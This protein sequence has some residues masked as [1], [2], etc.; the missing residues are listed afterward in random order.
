[1]IVLDG[2]YGHVPDEW[3]QQVCR[4]V[5]MPPDI[6]FR[7][8]MASHASV[9]CRIPRGDQGPQ[10]QNRRLAHTAGEWRQWRDFALRPI[11]FPRPGLQEVL[12]LLLAHIDPHPGRRLLLEPTREFFSGRPTWKAD[13]GLSH[14]QHP[15]EFQRAIYVEYG[16]F[17]WTHH[18]RSLLPAEILW[19]TQAFWHNGQDFVVAETTG[20][21]ECKN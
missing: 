2:T 16:T 14:S 15:G 9:S 13:D 11:S 6:L 5:P 18:D 12:K 3:M 8:R 1:M 4:Q 7:W 19:D 21:L 10:L 20:Y 17:Y